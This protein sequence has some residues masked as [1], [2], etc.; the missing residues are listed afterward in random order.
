MNTLCGNKYLIDS[1]S[2][3]QYIKAWRGF[4]HFKKRKLSMKLFNYE[5]F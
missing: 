3:I 1:F 2:A 4:R 5:T